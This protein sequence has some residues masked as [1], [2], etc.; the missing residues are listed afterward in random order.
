MVSDKQ[1]HRYLKKRRAGASQ[2][3][4]AAYASMSAKTARKWEYNLLPSMLDTPRHW[5]TRVD[6]L[7]DVWEKYV[8]PLLQK[9]GEGKLQATTII[10]VLKLTEE[11]EIGDEHLRTLQ[12]RLRDYRAVQG[13]PK[14]VFFEQLH[15]PGREAQIDFT[16]ATE[17]NVTIGGAPFPHL[18]FELIL[19]CSGWRFVQV[20]FGET[21]ESLINAVQDALWE[22]GGVLQVLRSDNLSAATHELVHEAVRRA[23]KRFQAFLDHFGMAYTRIRP[24]KSNENGVVEKGHDVFKTALD[25]AL[26]VRGCRDFL[27]RDSYLEF[28]ED[29]RRRLNTRVEKAFQQERA[30]LRPLPSSRVPTHTDVLVTVRKWSTVRVRENTYSVPSRLIGHEMTARVHPDVIELIYRGAVLERFPRL[31]G[32]GQ[33]RIDYRHIIHS[34]VRKPGAFARYRYREELFPTLN[35][36]RAYDALRQCRGERADV[37]YLRILNLAATTMESEVDVALEILLTDNAPFEYATVQSL[38]T[39]PAAAPIIE[40][41]ASLKPDLDKFDDLLSKECREAIQTQ[42]VLAIAC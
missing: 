19:S 37:E 22:L 39:K 8:V 42:A 24:G 2:E 23:T 18:L 9:D 5:R 3:A 30:M 32:R 26:I 28:V 36:R 14:E 35:F 21:F 11:I 4:A 41:T 40:S 17:L 38:V 25:Q 27:T 12:R 20:C 6:P 33:H 1:V 7:V 10:E 31:R 34:L 29:V 16:H 15:P 13:A